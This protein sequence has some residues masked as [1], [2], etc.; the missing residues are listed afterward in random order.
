MKPQTKRRKRKTKRSKRREGARKGHTLPP[1]NQK[2]NININIKNI[3]SNG[4]TT[5]PDT[6][7]IIEPR[8]KPF[9]KRTH[10][11]NRFF[12]PAPDAFRSLNRGQSGSDAGSSVKSVASGEHRRILDLLKQS[13]EINNNNVQGTNINHVLNRNFEEAEEVEDA[14]TATDEDTDEEAGT[15]TDEDADEDADELFE[16]EKNELPE[17]NEYNDYMKGKKYNL[18]VDKY[19]DGDGEDEQIRKGQRSIENGW[20]NNPF[21]VSRKNSIPVPIRLN[22][23]THD[24]LMDAGLMDENGFLTDYG[25]KMLINFRKTGIKPKY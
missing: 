22:R 4:S 20:V 1:R 5:S 13:Q 24:R 19:P 9:L 21:S 7:P 10:R 11:I 8:I 14:G 16:E 6:K 25:E 18:L 15:A 17:V 12:G 2:Q 3:V 23:K